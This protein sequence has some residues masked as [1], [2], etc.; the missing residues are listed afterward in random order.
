MARKTFTAQAPVTLLVPRLTGGSDPSRGINP[1][2][3]SQTY[4]FQHVHEIPNKGEDLVLNDPSHHGIG[5]KMGMLTGA[6]AASAGTVQVSD[7]DFTAAAVLYLGQHRIESG[8]DWTPSGAATQATGTVTVV[9]T[10]STATLTIGGVALTDAGGAR[11]PGANDYNGT[12]GTTDDIAADIAAAINDGANGFA[13]IVTAAA[14]GSVVTLTAVPVG[15]LGNAVT[16]TTSDATDITVS[17]ALLSGGVDAAGNSATALA[18][19]INGLS[20]YTASSGGT[21]IVTIAGPPGPDGNF[22]RFEATYEGGVENYTLS[23]TTGVLAGA[24][25][26]LGPPV[27][28]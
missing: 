23:P 3:L 17:G 5:T 11:T 15:T 20:G 19:Y 1:T 21:D 18:T 12:L 7:N 2:K 9:A 24:G 25:P 16:L 4:T 13:A 27:L 14:V 8:I 26:T 6:T 28:G 22:I 10:P